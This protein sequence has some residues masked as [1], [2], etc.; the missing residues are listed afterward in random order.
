[1]RAKDSRGYDTVTAAP[2]RRGC[3]NAAS[4]EARPGQ[5]TVQRALVRCAVGYGTSTSAWLLSLTSSATT[6]RNMPPEKSRATWYLPT[7]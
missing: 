4:Q 3:K 7:Q 2:H 5:H 6:P 1:M